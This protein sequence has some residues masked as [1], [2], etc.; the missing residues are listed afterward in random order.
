MRLR[1]VLRLMP[2]SLAACTWNKD[3]KT[4]LHAVVKALGAKLPALSPLMV[5]MDDL[6]GYG[7]VPKQKQNDWWDLKL[8]IKGIDSYRTRR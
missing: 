7:L 3:D 5:F 1:R 8:P 2:S 4:S 6:F